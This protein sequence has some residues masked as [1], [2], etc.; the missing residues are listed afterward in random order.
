MVGLTQD[1]GRRPCSPCAVAARL[2]PEPGPQAVPG[3]PPSISPD[4]LLELVL[5]TFDGELSDDSK[6]VLGEAP[7]STTLRPMMPEH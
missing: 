5:A 1:G 2:E 6:G 7:P 3:S 4:E